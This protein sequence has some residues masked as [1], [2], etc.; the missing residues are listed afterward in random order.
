MTVTV[1]VRSMMRI[2]QHVFLTRTL[3]TLP[4][5]VCCTQD[6]RVQDLSF[7][8][9]LTPPSHSS[10]VFYLRLS[11]ESEAAASGFSG[12]GVAVSKRTEAALIDWI[13]I[14]CQV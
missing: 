13:P 5:D 1:I 7:I 8:I 12:V 2:A 10:V 3:E 4:V 14:D 11:G 9:R 6:T